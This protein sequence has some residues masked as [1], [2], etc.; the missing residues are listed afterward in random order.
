MENLE[1]LVERLRQ[2]PTETEW[3]EF[4]FNNFSPETI[5]E[6][7]SALANSAALHEKDHAYMIW[8]IHDETHEIIGTNVDHYS[9]KK[10][11]QE[12]ESWLRGLLSKNVE[13]EF[14]SLQIND[15]KV[16]ILVICRAI[17][18]TV[19]F[20]KTDYIRIGSYTNKLND[21]PNVQAKLWDRLRAVCFEEQIAKG[22]LR[23]EEALRFL[24][25][26]SYFDIL[27]IPQPPDNDGIIHYMLQEGILVSQDNGL[28]GVSN[29]GALIFAKR[30]SDFPRLVRK[31][32]RVVQYPDSNRLNI[33][34]EETSLKGYVLAF[35]NLIK[36]IDALLPS[37]EVIEGAFREKK[38]AYPIN[39]LRETI[40]NAL[41]HQ[42]FSI[43]GVGPVIEIFGNRIEIT[44]SGL[45]LIDIMRIIDNPPKSRNEKLASLM[46]RLKICEELGTGWDRIAISCESAQ[47]P[48]PRIDSY[49][50]STK[51]TLFSK[52]PFSN[53]SPGDKLWACYLH[54]CVKY[55]EGEQITNQSLRIRFGL[56]DTAAAGISRLLKSAVEQKLIK[57]F[58]PSTAPR[59]MKYIPIWG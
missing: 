23:G 21:H 32:I 10:G 41:I 31:S 59:Y 46:R 30:L 44:N 1:I 35:E 27:E 43:T 16:V 26:T 8:G 3:L 6:D 52:V 42:D 9:F 20:K 12:I 40:A 7:I 51:V 13:F 22:D 28:Y 15:K 33:L 36:Y 50:S 14:R 17:R 4:K 48:A 29:L 11:G 55:V 45:P 24:E 5:G 18:Q 57:P 39:A 37:Q 53:I 19:S 58:D 38:S 34:K 2:M 56:Q 49:E 47:L 25:Y 54:A